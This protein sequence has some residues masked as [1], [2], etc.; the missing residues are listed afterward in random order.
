MKKVEMDSPSRGIWVFGDYRH[1]FQNRVTLQLIA[2]A[3]TLAQR[4][5]AEV[6]VVVLGEQVHQYAMEYVAHGA[7][8]VMVVDHP[9]LKNFQ[10]ETYSRVVAALVEDYRPEVFLAGATP[11]GREFFPRL[12]KRLK[13]GLSTDCVAL[14]VDAGTKLLLQTT[15]AFGGELLAE[16][17]TQNHRPQMATV[18]PGVFEE[19]IH[20]SRAVGRIIYP[21]VDIHPD[22]RVQ[23]VC[24]RPEQ[25][26]KGYLENAAVVIAGGRG[27]GS[28][29]QFRSLFDLAELLQGEVGATRPAVHAGLTG[30]DRLL[31]QTGKSVKP[32][33]LITVGTSG[34]LQ[35]T[36]GIQGSET[37]I[38]INR[39]AQAPIF[40]IADLGLVG[41]AH[42]I[43]TLLV[44]KLRKRL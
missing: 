4:R 38:A 29:E 12:A 23:L 10:V 5:D 21:E 20:D 24:S 39:D 42:S 41:D 18:H 17:I 1:Y 15:P 11:L 19:R 37:I 22:E 32:R 7:D 40:E 6:T 8:V 35:Y 28:G 44:E 14:E 16:V 33:L 43:L 26:K 25:S 31:G 27:I 13:T 34:A 30:E 3:K 2:K 36:T 9:S